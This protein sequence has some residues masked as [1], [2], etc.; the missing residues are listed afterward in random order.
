VISPLI[1]LTLTPVH[2]ALAGLVFIYV[3]FFGNGFISS[4]NVDIKIVGPSTVS[5]GELVD[6]TIS[7]LNQN[8]SEIE[9]ALLTVE[10]PEGVRD[11]KTED[12]LKT[13][14]EDLGNVKKG[15]LISKG[16]SFFMLGNK[17]AIKTISLK[18]EYKIKGSNAVFV[19]E[20]KYDIS[21]GS[22]PVILTVSS[23]KEINSG[24]VIPF[25]ISL[26][27]NSTNILKDVYIVA[28]Y[29]YGF[30]VTDSSI[31]P[32]VDKNQWFLGDLKNGDKKTLNLYG[33]LIAQN[34]EERTF[35][36][37]IGTKS[38][39]D[40]G[41]VDTVFTSVSPT[42]LVKRAFI[43]LDLKLDNQED[44]IAVSNGSSMSNSLSF[45]NTLVDKLSNVSVNVFILS[46]YISKSTITSDGKG[47]Y[48]SSE[49]RIF[50]NKNLDSGFAEMDPSDEKSISFSMSLFQISPTV[51][52]P[53]FDVNVSV[54]GTRS[55]AGGDTE[56]VKS[57]VS[58]TVKVKTNSKLIP[59]V[60]Y[61]GVGSYPPK[62]EGSTIYTI[63]WTITN[64]HNDVSGTRVVTT[65]PTYVQWT[66]NVE[67]S[68]ENIIYD[69]DTRTLAWNPG[70]IIAGA[71]FSYS[72]R[73]VSFQVKFLP[74]ISQIGTVPTLTG[75]INVSGTDTFT[76]KPI[77]YQVEPVHTQAENSQ[78]GGQVVK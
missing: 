22:S 77:S 78:L 43:D 76:N 63:E 67:P 50:W 39:G 23:P 71:G 57:E 29:P 65:L 72:P 33:K 26:S 31:K 56:V 8:R 24:Q 46:P 11:K 48:N 20:K 34:N 44:D 1:A 59:K 38:G 47:F 66:G 69:P 9:S 49:N 15:G 62:A 42:V 3:F 16:F 35:K 18:V 68:N 14:R 55:L 25:N 51:K 5:S 27:S 74:S 53:S 10:Y 19:K 32:K 36:F 45:R 7:V 64:T 12:T 58:K 2:I 61:A 6:M 60:L 40:L 17:D 73:K 4:G 37:T 21:I 28:E 13:Q 30:D 75:M 41:D 52:N 54:L 70:N